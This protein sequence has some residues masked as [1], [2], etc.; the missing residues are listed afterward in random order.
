MKSID[1]LSR[2]QQLHAPV[3]TT[4]DAAA[5]IGISRP[6][7]AKTLARLAAANQLM[8]VCRGYWAFKDEVDLLV[9]PSLLAAPAPCY[10]SLQSALNQHG[11]ISQIPQRIYA[12]START[13]D[14]ETPLGCVSLH[15]VCPSFCVGFEIIPTSGL[16]MATPEKALIDLLYFSPARS[17]LFAILPELELPADFRHARAMQYIS[18][19]NSP[20]RRQLVRNRWNEIWRAHKRDSA[21][22]HRMLRL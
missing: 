6:H 18:L 21:A 16:A 7:A 9:L 11:M 2:L 17:R 13:R 14:I 20:G 15:H 5:A 22:S 3:F 4:N 1:A 10:V 12:V 19:I 8:R